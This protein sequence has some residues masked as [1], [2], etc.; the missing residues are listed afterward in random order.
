M[1]ICMVLMNMGSVLHDA[2]VRKEAATLAQ[3]G[4]QVRLVAKRYAGEAHGKHLDGMELALVRL[5]TQGLPRSV[6]TWLLRYLE[7]VLRTLRRILTFRPDVVH[8]HDLDT[9]IPAWIGARLLGAKLVYD[10]HEL[11]TE[12]PVE[13]PWLWRR[14]ERF[15]I[16]RVD[17]VLAANEERAE[18]MFKEYGALE[19]PTVIMNSPEREQDTDSK[20][21][22][23]RSSLP[24]GIRHKRIILYQGGLS[25]NRCL[26]N[27][28]LAAGRLDEGTILVFVG[29]PTTFSEQKL[30]KLV[31]DNGLEGK[32]YFT[33][34]VDSRHVVSYIASADIGVVIY[35]NNCR[36]NYLCAPNKLFDYCL[37]GLPSIGCDFPPI[38][39]IA[40]K[41]G[42]T[43]MFD[44]E[45]AHSIADAANE[46]LADNEAYTRAKI[47]TSIVAKEFTWEKEAE[48]LRNLYTSF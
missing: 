29:S 35:K 21:P 13:T 1:K 14:V 16:R 9:L 19:L 10:S 25:A 12:R 20:P 27:L 32:V 15:L 26:E 42:V 11:Y 41:Y 47:A 38:R 43:R 8:A 31:K 44:P 28:T 48:K 2:R 22:S 4:H 18:I 30:K 37:A 23:L 45:A 36:N 33:G 24:E 39:K 6:P 34:A 17:K 46:F 7:F 40:D 5:W 3:A